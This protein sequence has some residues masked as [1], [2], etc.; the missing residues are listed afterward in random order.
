MPKII[1]RWTKLHMLTYMLIFNMY[2]KLYILML[3]ATGLKADD[4]QVEIQ[5]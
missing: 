1:V 4:R 3:F 5:A 2:Y